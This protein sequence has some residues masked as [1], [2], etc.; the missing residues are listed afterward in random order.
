MCVLATDSD[1]G[2]LRAAHRYSLYLLYWYKSTHTD[3]KARQDSH[4][5]LLYSIYLLYWY[6]STITDTEARQDAH[7]RSAC[8]Y[9]YSVKE[10]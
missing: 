3:T 4:Q 7:T 2:A 1:V 5:I 10:R 6:K 8:I 9:R